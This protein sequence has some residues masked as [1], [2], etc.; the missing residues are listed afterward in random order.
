MRPF[1]V[2]ILLLFILNS[3]KH[4]R[5]LSKN[6]CENLT[7]IDDSLYSVISSYQK[8]N[9]IPAIAKYDVSLPRPSQTAFKYIY[10]VKFEKEEDT[11]MTIYLRPDGIDSNH[12]DFNNKI[13]GV[14]QD[15]CLKPTYFICDSNLGKNLIKSFKREKLHSFQYDNS[16]NID[17]WYDR[18]I[19]SINNGKIIFKEKIKGSIKK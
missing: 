8:L 13:Y 4:K 15:S 1:A 19:Y 5:S 3:C 7:G 18:C 10:E 17:F 9:P 2:T 11:L 14:Y 16:I 12:L 6:E